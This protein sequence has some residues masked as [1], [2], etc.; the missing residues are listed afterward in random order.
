MKKVASTVVVLSKLHSTS[1]AVDSKASNFLNTFNKS[2]GNLVLMDAP[3]LN[4]SAFASVWISKCIG[5]LMIR[6]L[7]IGR[8]YINI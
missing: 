3:L 4:K 7:H 1:K 8:I 2:C 5:D 6:V